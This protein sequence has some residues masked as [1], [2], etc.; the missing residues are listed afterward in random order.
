MLAR[1]FELLL[2]EMGEGL[3]VGRRIAAAGAALSVVAR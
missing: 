1:Y 3:Q 2:D